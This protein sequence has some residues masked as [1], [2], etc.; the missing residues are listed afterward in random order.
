MEEFFKKDSPGSTDDLIQELIEKRI[1]VVND[2][3]DEYLLENLVLQIIK[4]NDQDK[5]LPVDKRKPI[6]IFLQSPGGSCI[7]GLNVV[8]AIEHSVTPVYTVCFSKCCSMAFH[9]FI[10]GHKRYAF[11][12]SVLLNHDGEIA[13]Q[14][15]NSKAKDTM[16]FID[17]LNKRMK[18]HILDH[19]KI[20]D[21]F[22]DSIYE[23]EYYMFADTRAKEL[24]C[25]DYIIGEDVTLD[26]LLR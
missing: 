10:T 18:Q 9:I 20:T 6:K 17:E 23:K 8:D 19:T 13:I 7:D 25:V 1:L 3:V 24:G 2:E 16:L 4:F 26:S 11:K 15:T 21:E 14:N 22:Y 12:N 5:D